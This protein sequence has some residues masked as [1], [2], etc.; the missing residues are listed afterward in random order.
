MSKRIFIGIMGCMGGLMSH[1]VLGSIFQ[2]GIINVY[3]TSYYK[4]LNP[5]VTLEANSIAFPLMMLGISLTV[6]AGIYLSEKTHP[7]IVMS[8]VGVVQSGFIYASSYM[9]NIWGFFAFFGILFGLVAGLNFMIAVVECNKYFP[10]KKM[11][12][13]GFILIGSGLGPLIFGMFCYNFLNPDKL[14]NNK[15]YYY[16]T[17]E[18]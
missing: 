6:T 9:M 4:L 17:P 7:L 5:T 15:G 16:G 10:G 11:Y 8:I 12:V 1:L 18:L 2:W 14:P 13:N 3:I